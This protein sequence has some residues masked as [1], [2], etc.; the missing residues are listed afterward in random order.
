MYAVTS[1][2]PEMAKDVELP[3]LM[4]C[5]YAMNYLDVNNMWVSSGGTKSVIHND[6][7]D[8]IN[9]VFSG[10]KRFFFVDARNKT[11]IENEKLGWT[12]ADE[13]MQKNPNYKGY[14]AFGGGM[15]VDRMDLEKYPKWSQVPWYDAQLEAGDCL[16]IPTSWYH[17]VLSHGRNIAVNIWWWRRDP[18]N[19]KDIDKCPNREKKI[20]LGDCKFGYDGPPEGP[21]DE[22]SVKKMTKCNGAV[23]EDPKPV[24]AFSFITRWQRFPERRLFAELGRK[25]GITDVTKASI[26]QQVDIM[27]NHWKEYLSNPNRVPR[28]QESEDGDDADGEQDGQDEM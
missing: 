5:G 9:C 28:K 22:P 18:H 11:Y 7:Q 4:K 23:N 27:E 20:T 16:Y 26:G 6:D 21:T 3:E 25:H 13:E 8:N 14:G 17:H 15:D 1:V 24:D 2:P 12:I 19:M 10:K